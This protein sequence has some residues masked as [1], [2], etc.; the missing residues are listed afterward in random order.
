MTCQVSDAAIRHTGINQQAARDI[1]A[2]GGKV[3]IAAL[4][5]TTKGGGI[6][7]ARDADGSRTT[8]S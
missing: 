5:P 7:M 8:T 2:F 3:P 6:G 4:P 1:G